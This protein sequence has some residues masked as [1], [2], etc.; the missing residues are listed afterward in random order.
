[1]QQILGA[2]R[3]MKIKKQRE[4]ERERER[5]HGQVKDMGENSKF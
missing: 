2:V 1:L 3:V 4:R 5:D